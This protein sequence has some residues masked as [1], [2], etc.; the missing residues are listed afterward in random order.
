MRPWDPCCL[1]PVLECHPCYLITL[2]LD[3]SHSEL[4]ETCLLLMYRR[5][6][7]R[8]S[9][10]THLGLVLQSFYSFVQKSLLYCV[11]LKDTH[12]SLGYVKK[13]PHHFEIFFITWS[14]YPSG[15]QTDQL[16][17]SC[18]LGQ[19]HSR[20]WAQ[21]QN[22]NDIEKRVEVLWEVSYWLKYLINSKLLLLLWFI[23]FSD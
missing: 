20:H 17:V 6:R 7:H 13:P 21:R 23:K 1:S 12:K 4:W 11:L 5:P 16:A 9:L 10:Y 22:I 14:S 8:L 18:H 3:I 19:E 15:N 2:V